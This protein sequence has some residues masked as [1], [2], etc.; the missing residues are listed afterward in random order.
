MI[1]VEDVV[2]RNDQLQEQA[3]NF[4]N[5]IV[6]SS[7]SRERRKIF[8][9]FTQIRENKLIS[10]RLFRAKVMFVISNCNTLYLLFY[11]CDYYYY[12]YY[13]YFPFYRHS[14]LD[15]GFY[16]EFVC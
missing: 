1:I 15:F 16:V 2:T 10:F 14:L 3:D 9:E 5:T 13:S 7:W 4:N 6:V 12:Y 8:V 11:F